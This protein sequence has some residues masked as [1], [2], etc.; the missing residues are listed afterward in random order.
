MWARICVTSRPW[1]SLRKRPV[2][3]SLSAGDER[4]EHQAHG[5]AERPGGDA[6]ELDARVLEHLVQALHLPASLLDLRLAITSQVAQLADRFRRHEARSYESMLNQLTD[7]GRVG[8]VG[9]SAG[10]VAQVLR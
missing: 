7:P 1:W 2:S 5:D 10:D 3:A 4:L 6:R 8:D 9:L